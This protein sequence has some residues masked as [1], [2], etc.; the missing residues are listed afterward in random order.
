MREALRLLEGEGLVEIV[1]RF[2]AQVAR[3][4]I[5]DVEELYACRMLLEPVCTRLA[6]EALAP[7]DVAEL[8][9][10]AAAGWSAAVTEPGP[11]P[12]P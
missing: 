11:V 12:Q 2:G 4:G 10:V 7:D 1:P 8:D 9:A 3:V 6:V 5:A